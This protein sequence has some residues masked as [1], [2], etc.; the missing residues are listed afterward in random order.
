MKLYELDR[1]VF[2]PLISDKLAERGIYSKHAMILKVG[3]TPPP[4]G[5]S[6]ITKNDI[7]WTFDTNH[8]VG[9]FCNGDYY[10]ID[11]GTGVNVISITPE[12]I[13]N[14]TRYMHGSMVNPAVNG[15]QGFDNYHSYY[16]YT[17]A[18]NVAYGVNAENPLVLHSG[19]SLISTISLPTPTNFTEIKSA[20]ILTVLAVA[21]AAG[22]FRPPYVGTDKTINYNKSQLNYSLLGSLEPVTG[23]PTLSSVESSFIHPWIDFKSNVWSGQYIHPSDNMP[24]YGRDIA[25]NT[26]IGAMMLHLN[27]TNAQKENLMIYYTQLGID[28][29][30]IAIG[31][32]GWPPDGGHGQGR[33]WPI[34]FAGLVL[35]DTDIQAIFSKTGD[36]AYNT[37]P[38]SGSDLK[39]PLPADLL[40]FQEDA[41]TFYVTS[42]D[43]ARTASGSWNPDTRSATEPFDAENEGMPEW[44]IRHV[45]YPYADNQ[46]WDSMYRG[47]NGIVWQGFVLAILIMNAKVL[48]NHDAFFD[49]E[50]RY[51]AI[52]NGDADPFGFIVSG[53]VAGERSWTAFQANMWDTYIDIYWGA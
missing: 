26:S 17:H 36:Y 9:Q 20:E 3:S 6:L 31:G 28:L 8:V 25:S 13:L 5:V 38:I 51:M 7:T 16:A 34:M 53:E 37:T 29:Y 24:A 35:G 44:G 12:S 45:T 48:W 22:S 4:E 14:G 43:I 33:K 46:H 52:T 32:S 19:D 41:D 27:F 30:N 47:A 39:S 49:Y 1:S 50:K 21:P 40:H 15:G 10:V 2:P 11:S 23:T 18:L 42:Y